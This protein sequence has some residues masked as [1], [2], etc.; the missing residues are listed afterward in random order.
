M[1]NDER[2]FKIPFEITRRG[3]TTYNI[4]KIAKSGKNILDNAV[5][6][7]RRRRKPA[8]REREVGGSNTVG[9]KKIK[10]ERKKEKESKLRENCKGK[11]KSPFARELI[12][13]EHAN[14]IKFGAFDKC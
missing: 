6:T 11:K 4:L 13:E 8:A 14:C 5:E 9:E 2:R 1:S 7:L 10:K 12:S 3:K